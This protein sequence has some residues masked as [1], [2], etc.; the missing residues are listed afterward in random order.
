MTL[1]ELEASWSYDMVMDEIDT[2]D[3]CEQMRIYRAGPAK[4]PATKPPR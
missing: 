3:F 2:M 1:G 4:V